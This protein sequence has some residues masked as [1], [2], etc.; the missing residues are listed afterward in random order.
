[1]PR[2]IYTVRLEIPE[3][4][5]AK[6]ERVA[7]HT[8]QRDTGPKLAREFEAQI[9]RK[10]QADGTPMPK[11]AESTKKQYRRKGWDTEHFLKRTGQSAKVKQ[12]NTPSGVRLFAAGKDILQYNV[13]KRAK[14]LTI[15]QDIRDRVTK[16]L[17]KA[18]GRWL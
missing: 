16:S 6:M 15:T 10:R 11:K 18:F 3:R 1:M 13:P 4:F 5:R 17:A 8:L 2:A 14:W 12:Q 7:I 9:E